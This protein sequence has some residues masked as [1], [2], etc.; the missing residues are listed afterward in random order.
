MRVQHSDLITDVTRRADE[1]AARLERIVQRFVKSDAPLGDSL[2]VASLQNQ[3]NPGRW[4]L[5]V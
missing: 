3:E 4:R 2:T 5:Q 1:L